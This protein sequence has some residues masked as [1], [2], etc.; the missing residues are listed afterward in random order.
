M[1]DAIQVNIT[2]AIQSVALTLLAGIYCWRGYRL[3]NRQITSSEI[4]NLLKW[5]GGVLILT[6]A[7]FVIRFTQRA[8][9]LSP[10][11]PAWLC[12]AFFVCILTTRALTNA[13]YMR[14]FH[15]AGFWGSAAS[16]ERIIWITMSALALIAVL[17][18][19]FL[20]TATASGP[21][22]KKKIHP[23]GKPSFRSPAPHH[24]IAPPPF[25]WLLLI[26]SILTII[27]I[28]TYLLW[29]RYRN[30]QFTSRRAKQKGKM[31]KES[32]ELH[33]TLFN[34]SLFL[35]QLKALFMTILANLNPFRRKG[36]GRT[37]EEFDDI[38]LEEP[39]TR[40]IRQIYRALLKRAANIGQ[41][42][43]T[44]E[45]PYEF[46]QRLHAGGALSGPELELITEAYV[47]ARYGGNQP[48]ENDVSRVK[49]HWETLKTKWS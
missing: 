5:G 40:S 43:A 27:I 11:I 36:R 32:D 24:Q 38:R 25:P 44:D 17:L 33:E 47:Q 12:A 31:K 3:K 18:A 20:G 34:W 37:R 41:P 9:V 35:A 23:R 29:R 13:S 10:Q 1:V 48:G 30:L 26:L 4:D 49:A 2:P 21:T 7:I 45:T 46:R 19:I 16:Q 6:V 14:R 15:L 28:I 8:T 39:A 22:T 42:R